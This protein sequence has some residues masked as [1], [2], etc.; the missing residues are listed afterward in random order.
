MYRKVVGNLSEYIGKKLKELRM[1]RGMT[2]DEVAK[3]IKITRSTISNYEIGRRTP[4][5]TDLQKLAKVFNV[6]LDY[7]GISQKDET[8]ELLA[9]AKL[10]FK[11]EN[12]SKEKK[13]KLYREFMKLYLK[14]KD[15]N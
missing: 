9:K 15:D 13:E 8:V 7:F 2:Q 12:V 11:N 14:I 6:G 10:V 1:N 4:H 5:L 3:K